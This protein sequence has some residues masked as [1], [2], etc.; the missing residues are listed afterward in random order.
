MVFGITDVVKKAEEILN[1]DNFLPK[2]KNV[3]KAYTWAVFEAIKE[4]AEER[5][6]QIRGFGKFYYSAPQKRYV[7]FLK[8]TIEIPPKMRVKFSRTIN[9]K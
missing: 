4:L 5:P 1:K 3:V 9:G 7:G 2:T 8:R 6:V